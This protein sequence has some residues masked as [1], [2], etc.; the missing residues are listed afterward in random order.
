[1]AIAGQD[2]A[3]R[4]R[5]RNPATGAELGAVAATVPGEVAGVV[6]AIAKVQPLWALLRVSDRARYMHRMAQAVID[7]FDE[8]PTCSSPRAGAPARR[9]PRSS[10]SPQSTRSRW[11]AE[12][13]ASAL[14]GRP[15]GGQPL[16]RRRQAR[17]HRLSALRGARGDRRGQR[18]VRP[19]AR[20]DRG[21][22]AGRQRRRLQARRARLPGR[23]ADR[24]RARAR[25]AARG[26]RAD[27]PWRR[28]HGRCARALGRAEDPLHRLAR[29][30]RGSRARVSRAR[31]R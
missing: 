22:P 6:A 11:I 25:R 7:D 20:P 21:R 8:L 24:P 9:S 27:R 26:T 4:V 3:A 5:S 13:G 29:V 31:R 10:C 30:G 16:A 12:D 17:P 14:G 1:M 15:R 19:A 23:R 28:R 18:P 2:T